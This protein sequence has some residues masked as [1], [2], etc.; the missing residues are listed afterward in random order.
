MGQPAIW[1]ASRAP[2]R[3]AIPLKLLLCG[4]NPSLRSAETAMRTI[5]AKGS[6]PPPEAGTVQV[7]STA[8]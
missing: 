7:R 2:D 5:V 1:P 4:I 3:E 8:R 6:I